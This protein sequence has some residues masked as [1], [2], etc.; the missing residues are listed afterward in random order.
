MSTE[1]IVKIS[2]ELGADIYMTGLG[3]LRYLEFDRFINSGISVEFINYSK[4]NY[5]QLYGEFNP[6]VTILDLIANTGKN[7]LNY[8]NSKPV[9][10]KEFINSKIQRK[11]I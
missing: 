9:D 6:Y 11:K 5:P 8:M 10:Y 7:A 1:R 2:K 4:T 3:A